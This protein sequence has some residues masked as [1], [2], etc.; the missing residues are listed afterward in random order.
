MALIS[1]KSVQQGPKQIPANER[2]YNMITTQAKS[3]FAK[4][5]SPAAA[6]WVSSRYRQMGGKYVSSK[7]EIDPKMRDY[8]HDKKEEQK[9]KALKKVSRPAGKGLIRGE[10]VKK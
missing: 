3:K 1:G 5:P 8:D 10:G 6:H 4:Y 7:R 2:L 9:K